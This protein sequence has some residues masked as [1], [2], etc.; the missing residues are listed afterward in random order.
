M[1]FNKV[2]R[3]QK[4][5]SLFQISMADMFIMGTA[6]LVFAMALYVMFVGSPDSTVS[7]NFNLK[8]IPILEGKHN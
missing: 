1:Q 7:K 8:V 4:F 3:L 5:D 2:C 6:M